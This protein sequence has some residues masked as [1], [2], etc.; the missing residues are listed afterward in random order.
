MFS[1]CRNRMR[2]ML[3]KRFF[4]LVLVLL[5]VSS[6]L[7][8]ITSERH[9]IIVH[10]RVRLY[11]DEVKITFTGDYSFDY[12]RIERHNIELNVT[13]YEENYRNKEFSFRLENRSANVSPKVVIITDLQPIEV[14]N[15]K[16]YTYVAENNT[17]IIYGLLGSYIVSIRWEP[18]IFPVF[19]FALSFGALILFAMAT[20]FKRN[21]L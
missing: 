10:E 13:S 19:I 21:W 1:L 20:L 2:N 3:L 8:V 17:L 5:L 14:I 9:D 18:F 16:N 4:S 12:V 11:S 15:V 7:M 6:F